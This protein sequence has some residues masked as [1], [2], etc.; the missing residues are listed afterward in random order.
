MEKTTQKEEPCD[1]YCSQNIR[2]IKSRRRWAGHVARTRDSSGI[3][4]VSAGSPEGG[5]RRRTWEDNIKMDLHEV[6]WVMDC[7]GLA[8][9]RDTGLKLV[10][11][12]MNLRVPLNAWKFLT[13]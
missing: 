10:N 11:A 8:Q 3:V 13:V 1:L 9:Y 4:R 7:I 5:G 6:R 2:V 12:G